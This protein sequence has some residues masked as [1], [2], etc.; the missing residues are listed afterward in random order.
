MV[1]FGPDGALYFADHV[2]NRVRR[3]D[4]SG[5][6]TTFA[7]SGPAGLGMGSFSG[8]GGPA[9]EATLQ[10]PYGV[11]FDR[12]G[13]LYVSDRDNL[14]IRKV[15]QNGIMSTIA[16]NGKPL[17]SGDGVLGTQTSIEF[18]LGIV[19]D[20]EGNVIFADAN[21]K[22]IRKIDGQGIITTIAGTGE[23][24]AT[25]DGGPATKAGLADPENLVIDASG[26]IYITDTVGNRI[27]RI[28]RQG[29]ITTVAG[30][31]KAGVVKDGMSALKAPFVGMVGLAIDGKGNLY[32]SD[33]ARIYRIDTKGIVTRVA[34]KSN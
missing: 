12:A 28:D 11:A 33:G 32:V 31:G 16:G 18:P 26:N 15:D 3:I 9:T 25:G 27:R 34:G 20:A 13:S 23:N 7:G 10:E 22:R 21:N 17:Y 19:A 8:D 2:N 29:I 30:S 5:I 1:T 24:A 6:I 14:R 4:T